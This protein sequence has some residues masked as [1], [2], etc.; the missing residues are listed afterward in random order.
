MSN[1]QEI[2]TNIARLEAAKATI[3][4]EL[5]AMNMALKAEVMGKFSEAF[6]LAD[7]TAGEI[8]LAIDAVKLKGKIPK[9]VKWD[10]SK[11]QVIASSM[12]W[13]KAQKVFDISFS[14]PEKIYSALTD[15]ELQAQLD[16]AR[17]VEYGDLKI[18]LVG[19]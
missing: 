7:K 6:K 13:D 16:T 9:K 12:P 4:S 19:E 5:K 15:N 3:E 14:V 10:S 11:L 17:T 1:L 18:E 2:A 8:T